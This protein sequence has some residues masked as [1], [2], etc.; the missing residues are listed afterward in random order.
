MSSPMDSQIADTQPVSPGLGKPLAVYHLNRQ[1][2]HYWGWIAGSVVFFLAGAGTLASGIYFTYAYVA[3][4]GPEV[5]GKQLLW[6]LVLGLASL[7]AGGILLAGFQEYRRQSV[8]VYPAGLVY[9]RRRYA[10]AWKWNDIEQLFEKLTRK[11][12]SASRTPGQHCYRLTG[13]SH[14]PLI[15]DDRF[16]KVESLGDTIQK[17]RFAPL[18]TASATAY[19]QGESLRFGPVSLNKTQITLNKKAFTWEQ[20]APARIQLGSMVF[21]LA[22][23][24][25]PEAVS[26]PSEHIPN[27]DVL[28]AILTYIGAWQG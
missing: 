6:P 12:F 24:V 2:F 1:S 19:N 28:V 8:E 9:R 3:E 27:L 13:S 20:I 5:A 7:L 18:Y 16:E 10:E 25:S 14:R 21:P 4:F 26:I 15:L 17:A 23:G 11:P 22:H